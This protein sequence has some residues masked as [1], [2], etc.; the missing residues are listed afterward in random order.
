MI[1][2]APKVPENDYQTLQ[3][4]A[5]VCSEH[6]KDASND[7][8]LSMPKIKISEVG[9]EGENPQYNLRV[10]KWDLLKRQN[11]D[12]SCHEKDFFHNTHQE[13]GEISPEGIAP[14]PKKT[15][16]TSLSQ[17]W[18]K[19]TQFS[20]SRL[21]QQIDNKISGLKSENSV[22]SKDLRTQ[23]KSQ[24]DRGNKNPSL[25]KSTTFAHSPDFQERDERGLLH[26]PPISTME[27]NG[28]Q[29]SKSSA[30]K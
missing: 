2:D 6:K 29:T 22:S 23:G 28:A 9:L 7:Q 18:A 25:N 4:R 10:D 17:K 1:V 20:F 14:Q 11:T 24:K 3:L 15:Y 8:L 26:R 19:V 30:A 12:R 21:L 5:K 13:N 16:D 27:L